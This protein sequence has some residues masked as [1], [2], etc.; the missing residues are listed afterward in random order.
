MAGSR[1]YFVA[2]SS[3]GFQTVQDK[4]NRL[5]DNVNRL[6]ARPV[7]RDAAIVNHSGAGLDALAVAE[8]A[9]E[10]DESPQIRAF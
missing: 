4:I 2:I 8:A 3:L 5:H 7:F 10:N 6:T 1:P 9:A